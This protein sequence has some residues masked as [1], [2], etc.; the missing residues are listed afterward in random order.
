MSAPPLAF[1]SVPALI[2]ASADTIPYGMILYGPDSDVQTV[3]A[4]VKKLQETGKKVKSLKAKLEKASGVNKAKLIDELYNSVDENFTYQFQDLIAEFPTLDPENKTGKLGQYKL[5]LAYD[6]SLAIFNESGDITAATQVFIDLAESG[7][8][9]SEEYQTAYY[10]ANYKTDTHIEC[11]IHI[12][13]GDAA[14][15]FH[16]IVNR[17]DVP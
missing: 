6:E 13:F 10:N 14:H 16:D 7:L 4:E 2:A 8:L 12:F 11:V 3:T 9:N 15:F 17:Q 5:L 1:S